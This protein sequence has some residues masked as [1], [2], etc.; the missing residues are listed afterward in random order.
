[1]NLR[2]RR[3]RS[4][5]SVPLTR[6]ALIDLLMVTVFVWLAVITIHQLDLS[7]GL[8]EWNATH[9]AWAIDEFT[10]VSLCVAVAL[11][12]FSWRRWQESAR[13]LARYEATLDQ[14]HTTEDRIASQDDMIR[15]V[16]HELR[17]PL[18]AVLGYAELL[19]GTDLDTLERAE[20]VDTIIREGRDLSNIV[21]DLITRARSEAATLDVALVRVSLAGQ[22]A[23][24][25]EGRSPADR[26]RIVRRLDPEA[27]ATGD[28]ARVRQILRNLL[29]NAFK[30]GEGGVQILAFSTSEYVGLSVSNQGEG[31]AESDRE[32]IFDPYHRVPGT[33][34]NPGGLGL[35][36]AI[37]RQLARMMGGDLEY[38][39]ESGRSFFDLSLS[40]FEEIPEAP[41]TPA[42][43]DEV[44]NR[45]W[46][47][48]RDETS[49]HE[50]PVVEEIPETPEMPPIEELPAT[51]AAPIVK[52]IPET[53]EMPPIDELP[54]TSA[55]SVLETIQAA[56]DAPVRRKIPNP[57]ET[58][59]WAAE[60]SQETPVADDTPGIPKIAAP[61]E[62]IPAPETPI[63]DETPD[64]PHTPIEF[65]VPDTPETAASIEEVSQLARIFEIPD[66]PQAPTESEVPDDP[67]TTVMDGAP[68]TP[69]TGFWTEEIPE[70]PELPTWTAE[71]PYLPETP[72]LEDP[73]DAPAQDEIPETPETTAWMEE[74]PP[75]AP[76]QEADSDAS[77]APVRVGVGPFDFLGFEG[78]DQRL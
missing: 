45:P 11:G 42:W 41:E 75:E 64:T 19:G 32:K 46:M 70:T 72:I 35:G 17:T 53:P 15:S 61:V 69:E 56:L 68:E 65:G 48:I 73:P 59:T 12:V 76:T 51:P 13:S 62:E 26:D 52:K 14:L 10:L 50:A 39:Y 78:Q 20:V 33:G 74:S 43:V 1:M 40:R 55:E 44:T 25:L 4:V 77:E 22:A 37:S 23:Q 54:A 49:A 2:S 8:A 60:I 36:L 47:P 57:L 38:R 27:F 34:P 29:S 5:S 67:P 3:H 66:T 58:P 71:T 18:T 28:P 21:E 6:R 9:Q 30:Y 63:L 16:S 24:V 31:I 7:A